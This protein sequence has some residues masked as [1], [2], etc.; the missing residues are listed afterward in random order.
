MAGWFE[1]IIIEYGHQKFDADIRP[2][3]NTTSHICY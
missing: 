2:F 1:Q 3:T